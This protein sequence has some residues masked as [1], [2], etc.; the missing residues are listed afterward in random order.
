MSKTVT[1][2]EIST[3]RD[4][5]HGNVRGPK[6]YFSV[7]PFCIKRTL[8]PHEWS[9][10]AGYNF[11][12]IP[13]KTLPQR[14]I[15]EA[16]V[17]DYLRKETNIPVPPVSCA[18][19]DDEQ[20]VATLQSLKSDVPGVPGE[21][22]LCAPK[23]IV[24]QGWKQNSCWRP[25]SETKGEF[26]FCH[27]DLAQ[28]NEFGGFWPSWFERPFWKRPGPSSARKGEEDDVQK[29]RDWLMTYC[30]EVEMPFPGQLPI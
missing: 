20:H 16:A 9:A 18:V 2:N 26:V 7:G 1:L 12:H 24:R 19:V 25:K 28:H 30:D 22:L 8:R 21:T 27:N 23:R 15:T 13:A 14:H 29:C 11:V 6:K 4:P 10:P 5:G 3:I 17:L